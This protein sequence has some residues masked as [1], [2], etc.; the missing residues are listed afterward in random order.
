M[1]GRGKGEKG[2]EERRG[3][4]VY[5][6]SLT[7]MSSFSVEKARHVTGLVCLSRGKGDCFLSLRFTTLIILLCKK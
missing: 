7:E 4:E 1:R 3:G 6:S 2:G 5:R